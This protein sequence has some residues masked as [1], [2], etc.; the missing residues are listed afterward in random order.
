MARNIANGEVSDGAFGSPPASGF[1]IVHADSM[2]AA[3]EMA[4]GC[5]ILEGYNGQVT[6]YEAMEM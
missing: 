1:S 6:V 4:Q 3:M 2:E 5:P